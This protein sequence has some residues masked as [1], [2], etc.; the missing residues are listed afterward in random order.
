MM[1][2]CHQNAFCSSYFM[3]TNDKNT[4]K[5]NH[6]LIRYLI[7]E[8]PRYHFVSDNMLILFIFYFFLR[9]PSVLLQHVRHMHLQVNLIIMTTK[10][11]IATRYLGPPK[12]KSWLRS[13]KYGRLACI[14]IRETPLLHPP[15]PPCTETK[16]PRG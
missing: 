1:A 13:S 11:T 6:A 10:V 9:L 15:P 16:I 5:K 3:A 2:K 8:K 7:N 14:R 12:E 4:C